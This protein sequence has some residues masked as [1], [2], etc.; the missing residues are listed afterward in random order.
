MENLCYSFSNI[1]AAREE[2]SYRPDLTGC[3]SDWRF[4]GSSAARYIERP[5]GP[6][7]AGRPRGDVLVGVADQLLVSREAKDAP[8]GSVSSH[9]NYNLIV[10]SDGYPGCRRVCKHRVRNLSSG[11]EQGIELALRV[12][13]EEGDRRLTTGN[14]PRTTSSYGLSVRLECHRKYAILG[15]AEF[16]GFP[17][18]TKSQDFTRAWYIVAWQ[19]WIAGF[20]VLPKT[21]VGG[22]IGKIAGEGEIAGSSHCIPRA[23]ETLAFVPCG[24]GMVHR[25]VTP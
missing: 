21:G 16:L 22:T 4:R 23:V 9:G 11:T 7:R 12:V 6:R 10:G 15:A 18:S 20:S 1:F 13:T 8:C 14:R 24:N 5:T 19:N 25:R 17:S 3:R 2:N